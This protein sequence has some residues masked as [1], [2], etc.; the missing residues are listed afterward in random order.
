M[1]E[2][3]IPIDATKFEEEF[4]IK[5][6]NSIAKDNTTNTKSKAIIS[7]ISVQRQQN[8]N[9]VLARTKL[10]HQT[11]VEA[12][13][14]Y[15]LRKLSQNFCEL[16][17]P[18]MPTTT[19]LSLIKSVDDLIVDSFNE[20]EKIMY[21]VGDIPG[22]DLRLKAI[23]FNYT[24]ADS[25]KEICEKVNIIIEFLSF[26]KSD[27]VSEW[28]K[29]V[30]AYG[31][32]LNGTSNRGGAFGFKLDTINKLNDIKSNDKKKTLLY[33]IVEWVMDNKKE[34]LCNLQVI[35]NYDINININLI[36]DLVKDVKKGFM[37]VSKLNDMIPA[38]IDPD[39]KTEEFIGGFYDVCEKNIYEIDSDLKM[40]ETNYETIVNY[41]GESPKELSFDNLVEIFYGFF[42]DI[43]VRIYLLIIC[44]YFIYYMFY[45]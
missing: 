10:T 40:L 12:L 42:K 30:L 21:Y 15:N 44:C 28:L 41:Y 4:S 19:E 20:A 45:F 31:N 36:N 33:F 39:D 7:P 27:I 8:I 9:V 37:C 29:I 25:Y 34:L 22:Y 11:L 35:E 26:V 5:K 23:L 24:F 6:R 14:K 3:T 16:L 17:L 38:M 43:R 32:Y 18:I 13:K 2:T 1:D